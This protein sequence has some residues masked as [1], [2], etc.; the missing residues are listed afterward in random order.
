MPEFCA[1]HLLATRIGTKLAIISRASM[2]PISRTL[3]RSVA[4]SGLCSRIQALKHKPYGNA[5]CHELRRIC[6]AFQIICLAVQTY[7]PMTTCASGSL[8]SADHSNN[9]MLSVLAAI[10]L[11]RHEF[12][13]CLA[14]VRFFASPGKV[15]LG[16]VSVSSARKH[17]GGNGLLHAVRDS[18]FIDLDAATQLFRSQVYPG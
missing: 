12:I 6:P 3:T 11:N 2:M 15:I 18:F 8:A 10:G 17:M 9:L 4:G 13:P 16:D 7:Q 14:V 1:T 5:P